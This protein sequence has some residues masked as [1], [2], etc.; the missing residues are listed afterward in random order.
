MKMK[1]TSIG[2]I[3]ILAAL[4]FTFSGCGSSS[5][6]SSDT[7]AGTDTGT[8]TTQTASITIGADFS[9]QNSS[10]LAAVLG[11]FNDVDSV[12][13]KVTDATGDIKV[14]E[15]LL[16]RTQSSTEYSTTV[17]GLIVNDVLTFTVSAFNSSSTK[18]FE[19]SNTLTIASSNNSINVDMAAIDDGVANVLPTITSIQRTA[20]VVYGG[21]GSANFGFKGNNGEAMTWTLTAAPGGGTFDTPTSSGI[22]MSASG[23]AALSRTYTAPITQASVGVY[24][25]SIKLA[26]SQGNSVENDFNISVVEN[27]SDV[28]VT[29][30]WSPTV[31]ALGGKRTGNSITWTA[32]AVDEGSS[33]SYAWSY[34]AISGDV[35]TFTVD[36]LNPGVMTGYSNP[37]TTWGT[38]TLVVTDDDNLSTTINFAISADQF[39]NSVVTDL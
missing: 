26:N 37:S 2:L 7:N 25:H 34:T 8:T 38:L 20:Q 21:T 9:G 3:A 10:Y 5:S 13:V 19:G 31:T 35:L 29:T 39:P 18:I 12:K 23:T 33:L 28:T 1:R 27:T 17:T 30:N 24:T 16:D 11:T 36:N 6:S 32:T 22:S 4:F 14:S 15:Q